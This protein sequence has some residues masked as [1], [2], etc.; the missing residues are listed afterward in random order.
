M[1]FA[2]ETFCL[3]AVRRIYFLLRL[4]AFELG[5]CSFPVAARSKC[6]GE[7]ELCPRMWSVM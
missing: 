7:P 6:Q 3:R 2:L 5:G 1:D 4:G